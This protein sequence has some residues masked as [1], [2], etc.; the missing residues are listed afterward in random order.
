MKNEKRRLVLGGI[1]LGAFVVWT[2]LV[3][4]IDVQPW[5]QNGTNIGF[6]TLNTWFH[7]LTGVHMGIYVVTDWLGLVP[8]FIC[9]LFGCVGLL[10]LVQRK[11]IFK[12]DYD[13][14]ILG[15]YYI[16]VILGYLVFER[17]PINYRPIP[18]EGVMEIS[19]PSSTTLL[20]LSVMPTLIEQTSRRMQNVAAHRCIKVA[21]VLF[22]AFMVMGRLFSGVHWLTD[23]VGGI[24][25][26]AGLF[27]IYLAVVQR[28]HKSE[29]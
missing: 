9:M 19:Y 18:I 12:V 6:A 28:G 14:L 27:C 24:L 1:L 23:I 8:V 25:L 7:G 20:V 22:S 29:K 2:V 13:I 10:Q 5:G 17:I 26:S 16:V 11:S 3:L 15:I 4:T 21:T